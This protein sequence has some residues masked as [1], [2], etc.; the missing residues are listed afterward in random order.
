MKALSAIPHYLNLHNAAGTRWL[1]ERNPS[2]RGCDCFRRFDML[3][4]TKQLINRRGMLWRCL[5]FLALCWPFSIA[6]SA[7]LFQ[8]RRPKSPITVPLEQVAEPW[9][10]VPFQAFFPAPDPSADPPEVLLKGILLRLPQ[11]EG[12]GTEL[13]AFCLNCPH[14]GCFV[15]LTEDT[16]L[17]H[18]AP[19]VKSDHPLMVC[20]CH[21]S[22]FDPLAD[23][24]RVFGPA[25]RG[26]Y[27]FRLQ[28]GP[29]KVEIVEVEGEALE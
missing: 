23:G 3:H 12:S 18:V 9:R 13:K 25:D 21:Y 19:G 26:L 27:R 11:S 24:A 14:E 8:Y 22:V 16:E 1:I 2:D 29:Q 10:P 6:W 17:E 15:N 20:P 28:T 4:F 7:P 5:S